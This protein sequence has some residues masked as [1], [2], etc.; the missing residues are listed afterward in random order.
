MDSTVRGPY[1]DLAVTSQA[2]KLQTRPR[3]GDKVAAH[4]FCFFHSKVRDAGKTAEL[5]MTP[6]RRYRYPIEIPAYFNAILN[7]AMSKPKANTQTWAIKMRLFPVA[8]GLIYVCLFA[9]ST[10]YVVYAADW[11]QTWYMS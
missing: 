1:K 3:I 7:T 9:F 2:I 10:W 6:M 8:R 11:L 5:T 4:L